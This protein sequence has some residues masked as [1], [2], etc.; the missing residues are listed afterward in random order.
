MNVLLVRMHSAAFRYF[1]HVY[2]KQAPLVVNGMLVVP[3]EEPDEVTLLRID[4]VDDPKALILCLSLEQ[5]EAAIKA[6]A[7]T[8]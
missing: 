4:G 5:F 8:P 6:A 1:Q 2:D 7:V 3:T